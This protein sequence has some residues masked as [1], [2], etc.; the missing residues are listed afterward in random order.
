M[1]IFEQLGCTEDL[2]YEGV[3]HHDKLPFELVE[4]EGFISLYVNLE[5][6][7]SRKKIPYTKKALENLIAAF[8]PKQ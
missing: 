8:N 6:E 3:Y 1:S 7:V 2:D 5:Y 4:K